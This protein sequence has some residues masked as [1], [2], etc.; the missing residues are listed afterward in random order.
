MHALRTT[1]TAARTLAC[2]LG[3]A[4]ATPA[5][6]AKA[7]ATALPPGAQP[8]DIDRLAARIQQKFAVPGMSVAIVK[9]GKVLFAKG[10]GVREAGKP[11]KV[12]ADTLF[13]IGSNTKAFTVAALAILVDEGKLNWDDKVIDRLPG[14]RLYDP[15]V[16]REL[17]VRDLLTHRSGLGLGSGDLMLFPPSDFTRAEIIHNL[18]YMPPASSFRSKFAYDNLL[19]IVAGELVPAITGMSWESF[20]QT[21]ILDRLGTGCAATVST[22]SGHNVAMPHVVVGD[23]MTVVTPDPSTAY[24][25]AG[26]IQC[27]ANGM[28]A[29][30][31]LQLAGG[32]F[33]DGSALFSPARQK[34]MWTPQTIVAPLPDTAA[35]TQT[36]FRN[37]GLAWFLEDYQGAERVTHTGGLVGMVSYVSLLPEQ[38]LGVIVLTNQQSGAAMSAM[39][40]SLLDPLLGKPVQDWVKVWDQREADGVKREAAADRDAEAA[41]KAAGGRAFLPLDAYVGV[42]HDAWRGDVTVKKQGDKLRMVFSRTTDM[43]GD[44]QVMKGNVFAVR[45]D[46]RTLKADALVNF[47]TGMD[48]AVSGMTMAPLSP[49]TDF[50]FDFQD[51][52]FTRSAPAAGR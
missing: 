24:D 12:D 49:T 40:Q 38:H 5:L 9:D 27:N 16:T 30:A 6:A 36:H 19:Y 23:K 46:D 4:L 52:D 2:V 8:Q 37:Y 47:R 17:T 11:D 32:K 29:W 7:P 13:G 25:P 10:Y 45:W 18:R 48:G 34:E 22:I 26:S 50:S 28:A 35:A 14:F 39:M 31:E 51:L 1:L 21:K 43:Q 20:V 41:I 33:K 3:V 15:Y 42:Y 44:M